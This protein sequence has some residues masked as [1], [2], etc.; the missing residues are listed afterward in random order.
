VGEDESA[1]IADEEFDLWERRDTEYV[2]ALV[3][4]LCTWG[5]EDEATSSSKLVD[6][7]LWNHEVSAVAGAT[8][9]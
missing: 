7:C 8:F 3:K 9:V 6:L 2:R 4:L 5:T 1:V